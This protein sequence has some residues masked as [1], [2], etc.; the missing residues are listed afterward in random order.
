VLRD[1]DQVLLFRS[2]TTKYFGHGEALGKTL[3]I[4]GFRDVLVSGV[5][6]DLPEHTHLKFDIIASLKVL[7]FIQQPNFVSFSTHTNIRLSDAGLA[8]E[9]EQRMPGLIRTYGTGQIQAT[10][11]VPYDDYIAAGNGYDY[12][13]QPLFDIHLHSNMEGEF[14]SN[15]NFNYVISSISIALFI[16]VLA[17]I[18]F[19][20]LSTARSTERAREVGIRKVNGASTDRIVLLVSSGFNR[21]ILLSI[22]L[23]VPVSIWIMNRWLS[24]FC[25]PG[26]Y[27]FL[28][29][30]GGR[31]A[32][33]WNSLTDRLLPCHQ[34]GQ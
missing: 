9:I 2:T 32:G 15:G 34:D 24:N 22:L 5:F 14:K 18:N 17:C 11:G 27:P 19:M 7:G 12:F 28:D 21:L 4:I 26:G 10:M 8:G 1:P 20:N 29:F 6:E 25:L 33:P 30:Y 16:L 13:L 23:S 3:S 31:I